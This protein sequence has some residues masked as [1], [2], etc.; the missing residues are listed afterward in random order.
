[1]GFICL[2]TASLGKR[3]AGGPV[4]A[5]LLLEGERGGVKNPRIIEWFWLEEPFQLPESPRSRAP[6]GPR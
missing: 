4:S 6:P 5:G 2:F 3:E 1:M